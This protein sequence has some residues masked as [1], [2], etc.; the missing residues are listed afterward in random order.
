[1]IKLSFGLANYI[2]N[3]VVFVL[4]FFSLRNF[5]L[6]YVVGLSFLALIGYS[7]VNSTFLAFIKLI[8]VVQFLRFESLTS[9]G[10]NSYSFRWVSSFDANEM[11]LSLHILVIF[12]I[13]ISLI[14]NLF[15]RNS[16]SQDS[17]YIV[18][19]RL[20]KNIFLVNLLLAIKLSLVLFLGLGKLNSASTVVNFVDKLIPD[21]LFW[22]FSWLILI[23]YKK[24]RSVLVTI[25]LLILINFFQ[26]SKAF[27]L[28]GLFSFLIVSSF[29]S[30]SVYLSFR[31]LFR[32]GFLLL[33]ALGSFYFMFLV[34]LGADVSFSRVVGDVLLGRLSALDGFFLARS[35]SSTEFLKLLQIWSIFSNVIAGVVPFVTSTYMSLG[36][37]VG[38]YFQKVPLEYSHSGAVGMPALVYMNSSIVFITGFLSVIVYVLGKFLL[39]RSDF[40]VFLNILLVYYMFSVVLS[41]NIDRIFSNFLS[42]I[43]VIFLYTKIIFRLK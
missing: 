14:I 19:N 36:R 38:F 21:F 35:H 31:N 8:L 26:Q 34:R 42:D 18:A 11:F 37:A 25:A 29:R 10:G 33:V 7:L 1:M 32:L 3:I 16:I 27:I 2:L 43:F 22:I 5:D 24:D 40:L 12:I 13:V 30:D 17:L 15:I 23:F 4:F 39:Y 9:T 41:G 20:F 6:H 28:E